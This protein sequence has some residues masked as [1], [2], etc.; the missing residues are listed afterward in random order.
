MVYER[1]AEA[2]CC[3]CGDFICKVR[4]LSPR[5]RQVKVVFQVDGEPSMC[6]CCREDFFYSYDDLAYVYAVSSLLMVGKGIPE[7]DEMG[8]YVEFQ[9][10]IVNHIR[11]EQRYKSPKEI[12]EIYREEMHRLQDLTNTVFQ[13]IERYEI[14]NFIG[15]YKGVPYSYNPALQLREFIQGK[16]KRNRKYIKNREYD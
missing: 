13:I 1:E 3:F 4:V 15:A 11:K 2:L 16:I 8:K 7:S 9:S 10:Y 12:L 5:I 6:D 14:Y